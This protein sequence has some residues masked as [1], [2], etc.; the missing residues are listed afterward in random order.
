[1]LLAPTAIASGQLTCSHQLFRSNASDQ[2]TSLRS[3]GCQSLRAMAL[4]AD[5]AADRDRHRRR[6][7]SIHSQARRC[8]RATICTAAISGGCLMAS[9]RLGP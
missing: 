5:V 3:W 4:G 9:Q 6:D 8:N 2:K 7:R 1:M